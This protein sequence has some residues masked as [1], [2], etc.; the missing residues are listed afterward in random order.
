[1]E[2]LSKAGW[3]WGCVVPGHHLQGPIGC[4]SYR[5]GALAAVGMRYFPEW[6]PTADFNRQDFKE[7]NMI[8]SLT[9]PSVLA[10]KST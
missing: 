2:H 7:I 8:L 1:V 6:L 3:S 10:C 4:Y 5:R 9:S